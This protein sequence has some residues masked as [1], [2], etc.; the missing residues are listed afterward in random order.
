MNA[1]RDDARK[2]G[3]L[4]VPLHIRNAPTPLMKKLGYGE[5]YRYPHDY[6]GALIEQDYL[7]DALR[8]RRY[9][10]PSDRGYEA[11]IG[12]YLK[13]VRAYRSRTDSGD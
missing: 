13:R 7:P 5:H 6:E 2:H 10:E 9:Y 1:A 4:P 3:A 8:D 12:D 11:R